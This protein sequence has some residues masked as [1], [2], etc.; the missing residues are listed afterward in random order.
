MSG[1]G[2]HMHLDKGRSGLDREIVVIDKP[3]DVAPF[4][5]EQVKAARSY[6]DASRAASTRAKYMQHWTAFSA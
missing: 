6:A 1:H 4:T 2:D 5:P 3:R